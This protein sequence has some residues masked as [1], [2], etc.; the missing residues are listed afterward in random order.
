MTGGIPANSFVYTAAPFGH[1]GING[2]QFVGLPIG[3]AV[4]EMIDAVAEHVR[5]TPPLGVPSQPTAEEI[6]LHFPRSTRIVPGM[7]SGQTLIMQSQYIG[8]VYQSDGK[9][10]KWGNFFAHARAIPVHAA[11]TAALIGIA[12]TAD[13]RD[14]LSEAELTAAKAL[15]LPEERL[16]RPPS[17][18]MDHLREGE[19]SSGIAALLARLDGDSPLLFPD[20]DPE[21]ALSIFENL[22]AL[23][24][25]VL[26][27][28]LSWSSFEFDAG[29][30]YDVLAT[31]GDTRLTSDANA[32]LRLDAPPND[33]IY[34]WAGE[35]I[36]RQGAE[37]WTRLS[38]FSDLSEKKRLADVLTQMRKID[39]AKPGSL[40][41]VC[42]ALAFL[43]ECPA[44]SLRIAG[45]EAIFERGFN[46]LNDD[47][48][49]NF[50]LLVSAGKEALA[51]SQWSN[52][53]RAWLAVLEWAWAFP[54]VKSAI[55]SD[56]QPEP[57]SLAMVRAVSAGTSLDHVLDL[58][59]ATTQ[60]RLSRESNIAHLAAAISA[61]LPDNGHSTKGARTILRLAQHHLKSVAHE[62]LI[63]DLLS[64]ASISAGFDW[65]DLVATELPKIAPELAIVALPSLE[66]RVLEAVADKQHSIADAT[67][68]LLGL[69]SRSS[70]EAFGK[71]LER[72]VVR[73]DAA[74]PVTGI[75]QVRASAD[76]IKIAKAN[77]LGFDKTPNALAM[78]ATVD[79]SNL[80]AVLNDQ[81]L[82]T[83]VHRISA[84]SV[85]IGF[86]DAAFAAYEPDSL[87]GFAKSIKMLWRGDIREHFVNHTVRHFLSGL[88]SAQLEDRVDDAIMSHSRTKRTDECECDW[89]IIC[90]TIAQKLAPRLNQR[91]FDDLVR[92]FPQS[93]LVEAMADQRNRG[94]AAVARTVSGAMRDLFSRRKGR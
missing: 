79:R 6:A 57:L 31:I 28:R 53:N 59:L 22:A 68:R 75:K 89:A 36:C 91:S 92:D 56:G 5:Y 44:D 32:Y 94:I 7:P 35:A 34:L 17:P 19:R 12:R 69:S 42:E 26:A 25:E 43:R 54:S 50:A 71:R 21:R 58:T 78:Q 13:W 52:S 10:G 88:T 3:G 61:V 49:D 18:N 87:Q 9:R 93:S 74:L 33:P 11:T 83:H 20:T 51:L 46:C 23:L 66:I 39:D 55:N 16:T 63:V 82:F 15:D 81:Q 70:N 85:Y 2:F 77:G 72:L 64:S 84:C 62:K 86:F 37:F 14:G 24:P 4:P 80:V 41:P 1:D 65:L 47:E 27:R 73:L 90:E 29:P 38:L 40:A 48:K 8:Q 76:L 60:N 30:G 45:A 67:Q